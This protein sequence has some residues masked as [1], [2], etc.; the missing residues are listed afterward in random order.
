MTRGNQR[1][2]NR[3]RAQKRAADN[4]KKE[5]VSLGAAGIL[6][7]READKNALQE[8]VKR[9]AEEAAAAE[10]AAAAAAPVADAPKK[11]K[12]V[13]AAAVDLSVDNNLVQKTNHKGAGKKK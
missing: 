3:E 2:V 7:K 5:K 4:A 6:G 9:K 13:A 1:D 8:K 12:V 11:S 10:A